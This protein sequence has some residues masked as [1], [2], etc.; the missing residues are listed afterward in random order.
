MSGPW[1]FDRVR[2]TTTTTA[3]GV[4]LSLACWLCQCFGVTH[5]SSKPSRNRGFT[6]AELAAPFGHVFCLAIQC[7]HDVFALIARVRWLFECLIYGPPKLQPH[8]QRT[9]RQSKF[10]SPRAEGLSPVIKGD[11]PILSGITSLLA[12]RNPT[13]IA[14]L[15]IT[16]V[17]DT[18]DGVFRRRRFPHVSEEALE[19][20]SPCWTNDNPPA[21]PSWVVRIGLAVAPLLHVFP[22]AVLFR[23]C[24]SV[25]LARHVSPFVRE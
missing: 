7:K 20:F 10:P 19:R 11:E 18:F 25:R 6:H 24:P 1:I 16:V 13:A 22:C 8:S 4:A 2:E 21:A 23:S 5:P 14:W 9:D 17:V 3:G 12:R 15:V